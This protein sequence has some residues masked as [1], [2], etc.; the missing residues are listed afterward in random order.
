[1]DLISVIVPV[2]NVEKYISRCLD[3]IINQTYKNLEIIVIDDGSTDN[4]GVIC[5]DYAKQ[6]K[7]I[8]VIHKKNGGLSSARN[9]GLDIISGDYVGF[10][11]SD[12][13]IE[14][15]MF[16]GL[17]EIILKSDCNI[18]RCGICRDYKFSQFNHIVKTEFKIL[19][20]ETTAKSV[21]TD[22]FVCNKLFR[23]WLFNGFEKVRFNTNIKYIEDEP[24]LLSC[25]M[26]AHGM[27]VTD[28][29]G[30][31]YF[32]NDNG[33][34]CSEFNLNKLSSLI[35]FKEMCCIC[36]ENAPHLLDYFESKYYTITVSFLLQ[37]ETR[38]SPKHKKSLKIELRSN[39][40]RILGLKNI[41]IKFKMAAVIF[42]FI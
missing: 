27:A 17:L 28:N 29:I 15:D 14:P 34:T 22:G 13:W 1:M 10:V 31:H 26:K 35:G 12:D 32:I 40:K 6:D 38:H 23:A 18:V 41:S 36:H 8:T 4:S 21:F 3:S 2:Y 19:D 33:L 7:R 42:S 30:Y 37:K 24:V 5:D 20:L 39:L 11:D 16:R 9:A 25:I